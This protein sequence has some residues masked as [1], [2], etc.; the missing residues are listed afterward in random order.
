MKVVKAAGEEA[1]LEQVVA[2][3]VRQLARKGKPGAAS[4]QR[5]GEEEDEE[6][7]AKQCLAAY[8]H[9]NCHPASAPLVKR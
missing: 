3:G 9:P 1:V 5:Q 7:L 4:K 8:L 2:G 6:K